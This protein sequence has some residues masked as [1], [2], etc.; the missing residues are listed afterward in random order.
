MREVLDNGHDLFTPT[1]N[2]VG[3][4][5]NYVF[6]YG[7]LKDVTKDNDE[8]SSAFAGDDF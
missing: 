8:L 3:A 4:G 7:N 1:G 2:L 6:R 5:L